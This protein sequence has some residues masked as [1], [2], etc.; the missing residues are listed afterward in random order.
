MIAMRIEPHLFRLLRDAFDSAADEARFDQ[1]YVQ[2]V[3]EA[4]TQADATAVPGLR[5][6]L[7]LPSGAELFA[8]QACSEVGGEGSPDV[9][10]DVWE[11]INT[12][13]AQAA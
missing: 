6:L 8:L 10:D 13:I 12:L 7:A 1:L 5:V 3:R 2:R 9:S 4:L 11:A